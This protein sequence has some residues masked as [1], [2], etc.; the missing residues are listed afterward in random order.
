MSDSLECREGR[1]QLQLSNGE[2]LEARAIIVATGAQYRKL[3]LRGW[4]EF[5]GAG[6]YYAATDIE[7]RAC[8]SRPVVVVG[9]ANSAGQAALFL[10]NAGSPVHLVVRG[11][12]LSASMSR[13]LVD[14]VLGQPAVTVHLNTEV[15]QLGGV[16]RLEEVLL[17]TAGSDPL[18]TSCA[19]LF[20]FIGAVPATSWLKG[21]AVDPSGFV[22]TD[23]D[24]PA[25]ALGRA[26]TLLG[27]DP[28]PLESNVP[29][30]FAVGDVRCGSMKRVAAA[31]GEGASAV[32]SVHMA[33]AAG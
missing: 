19:G 26:W 4:Q 33:L 8:A 12:D 16:A 17:S 2:V 14:R 22:Y 20:C 31:V 10:S 29:G 21:V 1:L 30:V 25:T 9:G 27:R 5:E 11:S 13:Y 24:I 23:R 32:R 6:I 7:A 15:S 18:R 3:P 28:L